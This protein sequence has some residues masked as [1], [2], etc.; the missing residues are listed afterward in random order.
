MARNAFARKVMTPYSLDGLIKAKKGTT[1]AG[2]TTLDAK[3]ANN[4]KS[5]ASK[6]VF[7]ED[8]DKSSNA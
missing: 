3:I 1:G 8:N 4:K 2:V 5:F 7:Y 6:N